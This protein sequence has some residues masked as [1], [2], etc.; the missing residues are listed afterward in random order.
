MTIDERLPV[1][2][3]DLPFSISRS[4]RALGDTRSSTIDGTL[5]TGIHHLERVGFR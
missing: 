3:N 2:V 4:R 1:F 5:R